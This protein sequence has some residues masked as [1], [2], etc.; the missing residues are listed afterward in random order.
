MSSNGDY[1]AIVLP[2]QRLHQLPGAQWPDQNRRQF[3][4]K[5]RFIFSFNLFFLK[6]K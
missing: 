1:N 5:H 3:W 6:R 4:Q 2:K